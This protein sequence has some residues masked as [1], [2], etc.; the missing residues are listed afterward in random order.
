MQ[1]TIS[2]RNEYSRSLHHPG[3]R[4]RLRKRLRRRS[5]HGDQLARG[6]L[7]STLTRKRRSIPEPVQV[8]YPKGPVRPV[9]PHV[10]K[11][12]QFTR[13]LFRRKV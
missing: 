5:R 2:L 6:T 11:V 1:T 9:A 12:A 7:V 8:S 13:R 10:G 4:L 3:L